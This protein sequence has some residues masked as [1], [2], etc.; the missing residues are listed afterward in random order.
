MRNLANSHHIRMHLV[1]ALQESED[2]SIDLSISIRRVE[3]AICAFGGT[4]RPSRAQCI[5]DSLQNEITV[6]AVRA[7]WAHKDHPPGRRTEHSFAQNVSTSVAVNT[8]NDQLAANDHSRKSSQNSSSASSDGA[9]QDPSK[10]K[11]RCKRCGQLKQNHVCPYQQ[12]L[13]RSIGVMVYPAVNSYSA[14]EPGVIAPSLSK[15]NN[16]ISYDDSDQGGD[17]PSDHV[18]QQHPK[19]DDRNPFI[20]HGATVTPE[21]LRGA[22]RGEAHFHSPQSSLSAQSIDDPVSH[23]PG[24]LNSSNSKHD[25]RRLLKRPHGHMM[26]SSMSPCR[27]ESSRSAPFV[28]SV[29]LR[30]EQY[31]AVTPFTKDGLAKQVAGGSNSI[32]DSTGAPLSTSTA[33]IA[34]TT[35]MRY[36]YPAVALSFAE[37]KRLSDTLFHLSQEIP[38]VTSDCATIL[39]LARQ[40]NEWDIAVAELLTQVVVALYCGEGDVRLDGLQQ[41]LLSIGVSC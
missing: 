26:E 36:H 9:S 10:L 18:T 25:T 39:R 3:S 2:R 4:L 27:Y 12:P 24:P 15:M 11:Y 20:V 32:A 41:Y 22:F 38:T 28:A 5:D 34:T 21:S 1:W 40:N 6:T 31:R 14:A 33:P 29:S 19:V 13:Q 23:H 8:K 17:P 7:T 37:R 35:K 30:P 16:F